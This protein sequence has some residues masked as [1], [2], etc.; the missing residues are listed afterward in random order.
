MWIRS[1]DKKILG[2]FDI[3]NINYSNETQIIGWNS[4]YHEESDDTSMVLGDYKSK[5]RVIQILDEIQEHISYK[6]M[7]T[8]RDNARNLSEDDIVYQMPEE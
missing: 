3:I 4:S 5:E 8:F 7:Y 1:Q 6:G 2:N